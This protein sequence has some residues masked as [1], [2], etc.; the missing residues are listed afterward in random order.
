MP[1][2]SAYYYAAYAV[3]IAFYAA[4]GVSLVLRRRA[5]ARRRAATGR[6]AAA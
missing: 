1:E 6:K 3:T 5:L 4:Y 2:N